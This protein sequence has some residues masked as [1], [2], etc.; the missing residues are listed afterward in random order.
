MGLIARQSIKASI[1]NYLGLAIGYF[2]ALILMPKVFS[3]AEVGI[4][5]FVID[6]SGVLAG[7]A[8][9][10][11]SYS[12]SRYFPK[13]K[14]NKGT[15]HN[16]FTFWVYII[17]FFGLM[18]LSLVLLLAGPSVINLLKD[19][20][21]KTTQYIGIIIPLS[22]IML[23]TLVTEQYCALFGRIVVPNVFRENGLRFINLTLLILAFNNYI[24]FDRFLVLLLLTYSLVLAADVIYLFS[25]NKLDF[26]PD[27]DYIK[28][29]KAIKKDFFSFTSIAI[30]GSIAP[31]IVTRSDYFSVSYIGGDV[32]LGI[33][34]I[35]LSIA[36]MTELPKRVIL[37]II[38]PVLSELIH[39]KN[40]SK[41]Y[42]TVEKG[43]I[44][45]TLIG[46]FILLT[47]WFNVDSIFQIMPNG[48][49]YQSGKILIL[50]L[51]IGKLLE[52]LTLIPSVVINYTNYYRW[53]LFISF[54]SLAATF[55]TYYFA[56]PKLGVT[57]TAIGVAVGYLVF[58]ICNCVIVYSYEKMNWANF[59]W[60][61][62]FAVFL[63][64][65]L[66]N[67][68]IPYFDNIIHNI[69]LRSFFILVVFVVLVFKLKISKDLNKTFFQMIK[70]EFR[71]F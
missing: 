3:P 15:H 49:L 37:P 66:I 46:M 12:L 11:I 43:N 22:V 41:L 23:Y 7:F 53:N 38:Q 67:H 26:K 21:S 59:V 62:M 51:G 34:S 39:N 13:F 71:W 44:N 33:Y 69:C 47:I 45:Q 54:I 55:I 64:M 61:K 16:G 8:S 24:D 19:G 31:L 36:V 14:N 2:N 60:L 18:L 10:G 1:S 27:F 30:I 70:G 6:I 63:L 65:L 5:R 20:G 68:F 58:A 9:L 50:I 28:K 25:V 17:P 56:V 29:N 4:S 57:G 52:L 35:A 32:S 48:N 40:H 42:E